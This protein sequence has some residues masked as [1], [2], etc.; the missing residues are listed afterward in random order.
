MKPVKLI[1]SAF[2]P[3]GE[4]MP[5]IDF[6]PFGERGLF[7]ITGDTGAGKTTIFDAICFA[8]Y[9]E[10]SGSYRDTRNLRS[11]YAGERVESFVDFYFSH[12]G[13]EYHVYRQ[14]EYLRAKQRGEG[15]TIQKERAVFY[16][17]DVPVEGTTA[18]N[19][20]V[21]ELLHINV[22][23]F[24]QITMIAQG[25]FRE[26]LNADTKERTDILRTIFMTEGY[27]RIGYKLKERRDTGEAEK[28]AMEQS[29]LQYFSGA[30]VSEDSAYA[31]ALSDLQT[32]AA[33]SKSTWNLEEM[34]AVLEQIMDEDQSV[35]R[36]KQKEFAVASEELD[37]TKKALAVA[38]TNNEFIQRY[39]ALQKEK[40]ELVQEQE[41]MT[42][43]T[44]LTARQKL[45]TRE[46]RPVYQ[47]WMEKREALKQSEEGLA[48][49]Q[50]EL[51]KA[52]QKLTE[53][54]KELQEALAGEGEAEA[55]K[56][57]SEK[58]QEDFE[59][60]QQRDCLIKGIAE[61]EE[62][63][64]RLEEEQSAI[65]KAEA[66]LADKQIRLEESTKAL[67]EKPAELVRI[68]HEGKEIAALRERFRLLVEDTVPAYREKQAEVVHGQQVFQNSL[69]NYREKEAA[70]IHGE[71]MLER[72]RAGLLARDLQDGMKC[73]VCGSTHHPVLA[74]LAPEAITEAEYKELQAAE[75]QARTEKDKALRAVEQRKAKEED[76]ADSLRQDIL[77]GIAGCNSIIYRIETPDGEFPD[78]VAGG[79]P[80]GETGEKAVIEVSAD[81]E[82]DG[83]FSVAGTALK[84]LEALQAAHG[85]Q[86]LSV[87]KACETFR[88]DTEALERLRG[89]ETQVLIERRRRY[90]EQKEENHTALTTQRACLQNLA[91]FEYDTLDIARQEQVRAETRA[92]QLLER[93]SHAKTAKE[94]A[95]KEHVKLEAMLTEQERACRELRQQEKRQ[96]AEFGA[97]RE[98]KGFASV[99]EFLEYAVTEDVIRE[100]EE[101][102]KAYD[103][104]VSVNADK[105]VQAEQDARDRVVMD[106][107]KLQEAKELQEKQVEEIQ[108]QKNQAERRLAVNEG[109]RKA[110][111]ARK[112]KLEKYKKEYALCDRL[113]A[114][115]SGQI[116]GK[117]KITLEQYI[118]A[119]GFDHII[120]AANR[121]LLPMSDNQ[122]ELFR[123]E[124]SAGRRS[125]TILDL[126]VL[127]HFTGHRRP[128]GS[129][130]GG[131]SFQASLS[132]ALGLSD[133]VSSNLGGIQMDALF[134][135]EGFGT[136][137]R[138]SM[139]SAMNI[140]VSL[141]G[142]RKLVGIIS[143]RE[144]L[145]EN[146]PQ[147]I[148]V[149]KTREGSRIAVDMGI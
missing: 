125:S 105:L 30:E 80:E 60:Y 52:R 73:P 35:F 42:V 38:H 40:Q 130:S 83:L 10:T 41:A 114:M 138:R 121:R 26:L 85:K 100:Q 119:A 75:E 99:E 2:G 44:R 108:T 72:S 51:E 86:E 112:D 12:Q 24:K 7:L 102:A 113:Y 120:A 110:I 134:I 65:E 66:A 31:E 95:E 63:Q 13:R 89:E 123:Q 126:E 32:K 84:E 27:Q 92:G 79:V 93:I 5:E 56:K 3:Y 129:L 54:V 115:V 106:E 25:E 118:Q 17:G 128:V 64:H 143:H 96:E 15:T 116:S 142:N 101:R 111:L 11:E 68:Q 9:G 131:E 37:A 53:A 87:Q 67:R 91:A 132:L 16:G 88:A 109:I 39:E 61:L 29:I 144:E 141:S 45:A 59:R 14:P 34:T 81:M 69:E 103:T 55:L 48:E 135:D 22:K 136:L 77:D 36:I 33:A 97:V 148:R 82:L 139:E 57:K 71:D 107:E 6:E 145:K 117:S 133:T 94:T 137:D 8:L 46:V 21:Q 28:N 127:D 50:Q 98:E 122:F 20:A 147:Q 62:E 47:S 1:I 49:R 43:L 76:M 78:R 4:T 146:I 74:K 104:R 19:E 149:T 23:Q 18:V 90:Q 140:L 70:R 58:L 124:D